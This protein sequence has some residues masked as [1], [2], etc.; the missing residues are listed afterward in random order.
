MGRDTLSRDAFTRVSSL[1]TR[2]GRK[3]THDAEEQVRQGK[4]IDPLV[5]PKG[6]SHLGPIRRSLP[7]FEKQKSLWRLVMNMPMAEETLL[8]TTG[9]MQQNVE[10]AFAA[11]PKSFGM[12]TE[13]SCPVLG[14]YDVQIAT[15]IFNDVD[16]LD[17]NPYAQV[18][19]RSQFEMGE[20]IALQMTRMIPGRNGCGNFKEDSQ[21]GLFGAAYLTDARITKYG[22][23]TYHFTVSDEPT[24]E[25]IELG[26]LKKIFGDDV[27]E[28][29][30]ENGW[31][32]TA[33][34][35]PDTA[36]AV[37]DLQTRAHAFFL[38]VPGWHDERRVTNQWTELYGPAHFVM[39]P[40]GTEYVHAVKGCIIGLTEGVI[41]LS[42]AKDFLREHGVPADAAAKIV[43]AVAH[44]PLA[45][46]TLAP[47]FDKLPKVGDLFKEKT[48]LWPV[49]PQEVPE[50][51][52]EDKDKGEET[53]WL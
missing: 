4:G 53:E 15:G 7:R 19:C 47:N 41:S 50:A 40:G 35:L 10:L 17:A 5:D 32:F 44:I 29:T 21:F 52:V 6:P 11:L 20:K 39:L 48:D 9:S 3:A 38:Q 22:L 16:D 25:T 43:R 51:T 26:W 37:R 28:R 24:V 31:D 45:A 27:L 18:L 8:D 46:Q 49:D 34:T 30:A 36:Q 42:S 2:G 1:A 23:R 13:G 12:Y 14:R 33:R